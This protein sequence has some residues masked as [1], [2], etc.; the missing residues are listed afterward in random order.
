L[1]SLTR[2]AGLQVSELKIRDWSC[3]A[4]DPT[5]KSGVFLKYTCPDSSRWQRATLNRVLKP[6]YLTFV[7]RAPA[8]LMMASSSKMV[9]WRASKLPE[10]LP[11]PTQMLDGQQRPHTEPCAPAHS[12]LGTPTT[13]KLFED[14][15][16][17]PWRSCSVVNG[18]MQAGHPAMGLFARSATPCHRRGARTIAKDPARAP[19]E[20]LSRP[21]EVGACRPS[22]RCTG[23]ISRHV[24]CFNLSRQVR[25][26]ILKTGSNEA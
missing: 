18:T 21:H 20:Q 17:G 19:R 16:V 10:A 14:L 7:H 13:C 25:V 3:T 1:G 15:R 8:L 26:G 6:S 5:H 2:K 12:V 11:T 24:P 9:P 22:P 23:M 4:F